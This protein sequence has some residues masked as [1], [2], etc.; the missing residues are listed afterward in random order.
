VNQQAGFFRYNA[1]TLVW[2]L[3]IAVLVLLPGQNLPK[4]SDSI[5]SIDKLVHAF[6]FAGLAFLMIVGFIKQ[7]A[8]P[9]LR[10]KALPY[11]FMLTISYAILVEVLQLFSSERVFELLDMAANISGVFAG[12]LSFFVLYKL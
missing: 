3:L 2:S 1:Y 8:Y 10:N 5:F 4:L 7:G 11:A 6:L 12:F 9:A